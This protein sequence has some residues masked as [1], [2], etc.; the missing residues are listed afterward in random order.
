RSNDCDHNLVP[1]ECQPDFDGDGIIDACDD[2]IDNDG[3]PNAADA[4]N[5]TG[6]GT[7][8]ALNGRPLSDTTG[9]CNVGLPDYWRFWN[10]TV[11]GRLGFP[12]PAEA[13]HSFFDYD[14]DGNINLRD[15]AG[16]QNGFRSSG[17]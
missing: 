1:D 13:C 14:G 2:D 3:V 4:C 11:N 12:A 16:L 7:P 17:R 6:L 5:R 9:Q 8:V 15:F 10:C